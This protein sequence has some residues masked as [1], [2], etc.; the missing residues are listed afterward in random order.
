MKTLNLIIIG[1]LLL[2]I[3][4]E[5]G[6]L[7]I[8]N[9]HPKSIST[10]KVVH[11]SFDDV[12][13]VLKELKKNTQVYQ[14]IFNCEFFSELKD[15]HDVYGAKFTLYIFEKDVD[16]DIGDMPVKF[17]NEFKE[18][19][20]WLKFG[21]H[22]IEPSVYNEKIES[23]I[24]ITSF[25][26]TQNAIYSF[27]DS[28]NVSSIIRL[29]YFKG[30]IKN[31]NSGEGRIKGVLCADDERISYNLNITENSLVQ[32]YNFLYKDSIKYF[33][34]N[35]RY[36]KVWL[37]NYALSSL[38]DRDTLIL[39]THEWA[40]TPVTMKQ[41][42][43]RFIRTGRISTNWM[44]RYNLRESIKWLKENEYKFSFLE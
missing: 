20:A 24:L 44:T 18:N 16:F 17:R 12:I 43:A 36:E 27:A 22:G 39:F 1:L 38:Q 34:T 33:K 28:T 2:A 13:N 40:F 5:G 19:S 30:D 6:C 9:I 23:R 35:L 29:H 25:Q 14:S 11:I 4:I 21:F 3:S 32:K 26:H 8:Q 37:I 31:L 10:N 7:I 42:F 41:C 15:L